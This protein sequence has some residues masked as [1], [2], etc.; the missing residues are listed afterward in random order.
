MPFCEICGEHLIAKPTSTARYCSK[1]RRLIAAEKRAQE[2]NKF[3][4]NSH[5]RTQREAV[6]TWCGN[7]FYTNIA[8]QRKCDACREQEHETLR[9]HRP[10][11]SKPKKPKETN[12][13]A[14]I[15]LNREARAAGMSYG[16]YV[17][18]LGDRR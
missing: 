5:D 8:T 1:C 2:A 4:K 6:C 15:R 18:S 13:E 12:T 10:R 14:L 3:R 11:V 16:E 7:T 17:A 9:P